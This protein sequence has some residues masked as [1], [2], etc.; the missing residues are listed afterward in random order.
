MYAT[1]TNYDVGNKDMIVRLYQWY[2]EAFRKQTLEILGNCTQPNRKQK[3]AG[4]YTVVKVSEKWPW[5][6]PL[7]PTRLLSRKCLSKH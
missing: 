1:N 3:Q 7:Q 6:H 4:I 2:G 5:K